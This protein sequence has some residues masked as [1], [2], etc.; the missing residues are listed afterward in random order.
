VVDLDEQDQ[1]AG[2]EILDATRQMDVA[3]VLRQ[4]MEKEIP[5]SV[6]AAQVA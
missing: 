1:L 2:L 6:A 4:M 5:S 3:H